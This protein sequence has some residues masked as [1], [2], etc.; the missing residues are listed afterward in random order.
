MVGVGAKETAK[1]QIPFLMQNYVKSLVF[2]KLVIFLSYSSTYTSGVITLFLRRYLELRYE[3]VLTYLTIHRIYLF[4]VATACT[5]CTLL[6]L[7]MG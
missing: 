7:F 4:P 3:N 1:A 2:A 5:I 6:H